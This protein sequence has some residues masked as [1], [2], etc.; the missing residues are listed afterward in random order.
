[1]SYFTGD[2]E[3]VHFRHWPAH[4]A[5]SGLVLLHEIGEE[6][7]VCAELAE[8][9]NDRQI[10]V[11]A[12]S[13]ISESPYHRLPSL[14]TIVDN[15]RQLTAIAELQQPGLPVVL[16][17][18]SVGGTAAALTAVRNPGDYLALILFGTPVSRPGWA[19]GIP[20]NGPVSLDFD[21][22]HHVHTTGR[23]RTRSDPAYTAGALNRAWAE[24]AE[25]FGDLRLPVEFLHGAYDPVVPVH[26]N[27]AWAQRLD[28]A[29]LTT[30]DRPGRNVLSAMSP[31]RAATT[32]ADFVHAIS[33]AR[34]AA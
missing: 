20:A 31:L 29:E 9:L 17:G 12:T 11:W 34:T 18:Q 5:L 15:A 2:H 23:A 22:L 4:R 26:D 6:P 14:D 28:M 13:G 8:A 10:S 24:L 25:R 21:H 1:M 19:D 7:D 32:I 3:Q 27:L 16:A 30:F 33:A